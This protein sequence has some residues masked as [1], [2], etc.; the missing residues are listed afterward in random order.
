MSSMKSV[1]WVMTLVGGA[2]PGSGVA[3]NVTSP[4]PTRGSLNVTATR[5]PSAL[6]T[7]LGGSSPN[8]F[9]QA[10]KNALASH[11]WASR[12]GL[13]VNASTFLTVPS[14]IVV[15]RRIA[16]LKSTHGDCC[17]ILAYSF[18][19][20]SGN[21]CFRGLSRSTRASLKSASVRFAPVKSTWRRC[22]CLRFA[23]D[24]FA[25]CRYACVRSAPHRTAPDRF[26]PC[27]HREF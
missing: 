16:T 13:S 2:C 4:I 19:V 21:G 3:V 1:G 24:R 5:T 17:N 12:S 15:L 14:G 10:S 20:W 8:S 25:P 27:R 7:A 11:V 23:P 18:F 6:T 22:A 26:A 9:T